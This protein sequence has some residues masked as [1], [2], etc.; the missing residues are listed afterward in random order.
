MHKSGYQIRRDKSDGDRH[1]TQRNDEN[2][3]PCGRSHVELHQSEA[4]Q[5]NNKIE[6]GYGERRILEFVAKN[7]WFREFW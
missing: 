5:N 6:A 3:I 7:N 4:K 1:T 2:S